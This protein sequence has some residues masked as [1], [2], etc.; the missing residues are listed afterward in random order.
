MI[1]ALAR[2]ELAMLWR[3]R[4]AM[5]ALASIA[6]LVLL[7]FAGV[8]FDAART[9]AHKRDAAAAERARWLGQGVK[10]PHS[11]AHHAVYAFK[12]AP[13]LAPLDP[14]VGPFV[15]QAVWLEAHHQNDLLHRPQQDAS[16]LQRAGLAD[17][18]ALILGFGPLALFLLAF[19]AVAEERERGTLRLAL[20]AATRPGRIVEAKLVAVAGS[21]I[22]ALVVPVALGTVALAGLQDALD[23]DAV[24]RVLLWTIAVAGYLATVAAIGL[25]VAMTTRS[26]RIGLAV[27]FG[28]WILFALALPR[29]ASGVANDLRPLPSTQAVRQEIE[30]AAPAYW[31]AEDGARHRA[32]L[33]AR[34]GVTRVEDIP[35]YRM[36]E[37]DLVERHSHR[38]FD[39]VLGDFYAKVARQDRLFGLFGILSPTIAMQRLSPAFAGTDFD[40]HRAFIEQ[41]ESYRRD[42]VDRMNAEGMAHAVRPGEP[43]H[44]ADIDL[45]GSIPPFVFDPPSAA[46]SLVTVP[47]AALIGW[48]V[49]AAT[50]L[51]LASRRL[52]P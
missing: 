1:M 34:H 3:E 41:A 39:R 13:V 6:A 7:A 32:A 37:L 18:A 26:A 46:L 45:W 31:S 8:A 11:A 36:A 10:D 51:G 5:L 40:Q 22:V 42:L 25:A 29:L 47:L 17:P 33:L 43:A 49:G 9:D 15:G 50:L 48:M 44:T 27:L 16:P 28:L 35:N 20:G 52:R 23:G 12:P 19:A 24:L 4:R 21:G 2:F 14:G 38:V 30:Q